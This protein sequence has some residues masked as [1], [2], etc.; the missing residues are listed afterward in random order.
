M[1]FFWVAF[2]NICLLG[3]KFILLATSFSVD[4]I[5]SISLGKCKI[6]N[7]FKWNLFVDASIPED[8]YI[9]SVNFKFLIN[10]FKI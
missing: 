8:C 9:G 7:N 3:P 5:E 4:V 6:T 10:Y 2:L 1:R